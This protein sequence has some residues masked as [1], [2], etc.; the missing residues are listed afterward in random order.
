[1]F[2][3]Y[4]MTPMWEM[5][6]AKTFPTEEQADAFAMEET[7][8][9]ELDPDDPPDFW[10]KYDPPVVILFEAENSDAM[11]N[12]KYKQPTAIY[13]HG[14]KYICIKSSIAG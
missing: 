8:Y 11:M 1:M 9:I 14:D 5:D 3:A 12:G 4:V 13:Q 6:V 10:E 7:S 2:I